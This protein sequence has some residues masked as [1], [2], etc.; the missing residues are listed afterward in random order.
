MLRGCPVCSTPAR[1]GGACPGCGAAIPAR[2]VVLPVLLG[3]AL[4]GC[5]E[6]KLVDTSTMIAMYGTVAGDNDGDGYPSS[7]AGGSDCDDADE[8]IHPEAEETAGD[9]VDSN[10]DGADDT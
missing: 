1:A 2:S 3:L 9:G 6:A 4:A 10:C 7:E 5:D 8:T